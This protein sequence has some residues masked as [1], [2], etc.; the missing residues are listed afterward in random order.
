[1]PTQIRRMDVGDIDEWVR[2]RACLWS[3]L[4]AAGHRAE[5]MAELG[6]DHHR[7]YLALADDGR[8]LGFAELSIR[9]YANGCTATPVP[10]L[11]GIW[12]EPDAR[13]SGTGGALLSH[14]SA[15]L[16]EEGYAELCSDAEIDNI[17]SHQAHAAWGFAETKRVVYFR[18]PL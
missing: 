17:T 12:V 4:D 5:V 7:A 8:A 16:R 15:V 14:I 3:S 18:K 11:E 2:M 1:M 6:K 9:A 10:F 13:R